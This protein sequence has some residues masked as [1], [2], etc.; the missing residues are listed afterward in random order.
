MEIEVQE[1]TH[2]VHDQSTVFAVARVCHHLLEGRTVFETEPNITRLAFCKDL[3]EEPLG[4]AVG[5]VA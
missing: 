2:L 5:K 1:V 3:G 4:P